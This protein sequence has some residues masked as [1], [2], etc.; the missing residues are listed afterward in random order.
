MKVILI[1]ILLIAIAFLGLGF[2][3]FFRKNGKF[4]ETEIGHNKHMKK[5]GITCVKCDEGKKTSKRLLIQRLNINPSDLK[6]DIS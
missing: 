5:L 6:L 3:I 2:S 1:S 4:P